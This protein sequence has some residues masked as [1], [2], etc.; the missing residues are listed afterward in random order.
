MIPLLVLWHA[1]LGLLAVLSIGLEDEQRSRF[2]QGLAVAGGVGGLL[3]FFGSPFL[4]DSWRTLEL[5][6]SGTR[7]AGIATGAAWIL[8]AVAERSRGGGRWDVVA[9]TGVA[10]TALCMFGLNGWTVPALL[11]G[12][13]AAL[14]TVMSMQRPGIVGAFVAVGVALLAGSLLWGVL[15]S[16]SWRI[17]SPVSGGRLWLAVAGGIAFAT[18]AVLSESP[19]RPAPSTPLVLGLAFL[20]F[21]TVARAAG[22]VIALAVIA[23]ALVAVIWTLIRETVAQRVVVVWVIALSVGLATLTSNPYVA[24]RSAVAA[25]LAA[26]VLRLWPLSLGR[27]QIERGVLVAFVAMTAGFNAIA[28]AASYSFERSMGLE[29]VLEVAPWAGVSALLPVALAGG[30]VLGAS[31]GRNPEPEDYTRSGVLGSWALVILSVMVGLFPYMG[32]GQD[33]GLRGPGL[34]ILALVAGVAAARYVRPT[35]AGSLP[36]TD[37][38]FLAVPLTV[39]WPRAAGYATWAVAAAAALAI[40]AAT[41]QGL[42][43]GFL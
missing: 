14:A 5:T 43:V 38:R 15:D 3:L 20:T 41:F 37:S 13:I 33:A 31:I 36:A 25:I 30:V 16:E 23:V 1:A 21:A 2:A 4:E 9:T 28:A 40:V 42:R 12:G 26:T 18:A 11:F 29:R 7:I 32:P 22:P 24:T 10:A 8:V 19:D 6:P 27:A 35:A 34:Y 39:A 17:A